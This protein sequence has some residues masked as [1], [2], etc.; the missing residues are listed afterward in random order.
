MESFGATPPKKDDEIEIE[1][2]PFTP[3]S[4]K[5]AEIEDEEHEIRELIGM[6]P[7][8]ENLNEGQKTYLKSLRERA[9]LL[10]EDLDKIRAEQGK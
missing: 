2:L 1:L 6:G 7:G 9:K 5:L 8:E 3:E 4:G 10:R